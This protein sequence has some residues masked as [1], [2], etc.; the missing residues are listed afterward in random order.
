[1]SVVTRVGSLVAAVVLAASCGTTSSSTVDPVDGLVEITVTVGIDSGPDRIVQIPFGASVRVTIINP[2]AADEYHLHG[3]DIASGSDI[4]GGEKAVI[5][6]EAT[7][8]GLFEIESH[9]S[10]QV[11]IVLEIS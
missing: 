8:S 1:M 2:D 6:F 9:A 11:L 4:P 3:Y 10:Q 7:K 5:E